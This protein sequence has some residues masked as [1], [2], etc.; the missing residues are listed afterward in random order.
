MI[1]YITK[2][3]AKY[4]IILFCIE[5]LPLF[6]NVNDPQSITCFIFMYNI[7][8]EY[9]CFITLETIWKDTYKHTLVLMT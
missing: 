2:F 3:L 5:K 9:T 8:Y 7:T 4:Y 6:Y 1:Y